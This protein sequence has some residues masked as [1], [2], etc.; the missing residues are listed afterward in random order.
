[1]AAPA[2]RLIADIGGTNARFALTS[3][4]GPVG[5]TTVMQ[6]RA[7]AT[8]ADALAAYVAATGSRFH[9]AALAAAGPRDGDA[10][11][12][13]NAGW[14]IDPAG[15]RMVAPKAAVAV[16][17]DLEAVAFALPHLRTDD[18]DVLAAGAPPAVPAPRLAF[19]VGTGLGAAVA[20]PGPAGWRALATEAGHMRFAAAT[21]EEAAIAYAFHTYEDALSGRGFARLEALLPDAR[22]RRRVFSR[23]LGRVAGD[24][25]LATGAWGG[26]DFCGG[27][28]STWEE[29]VDFA[30][31]KQTFLDKGP[32]AA[33]MATVPIRRLTAAAPALIG[34]AHAPIA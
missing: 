21:D 3:A 8:F 15:V 27:V 5:P 14:T 1:M 22:R 4:G 13:T 23:L 2:S 16:F 32:M 12:L 19:N 11:R 25:T 33:R 29:N 20:L 31:L 34:L 10:I 18:V 24:L 9:E 7:H 30:A 26:I 6:V 17:N 28:L